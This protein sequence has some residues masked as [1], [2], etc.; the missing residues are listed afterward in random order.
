MEEAMKSLVTGATGFIGSHLAK[1][2][3]SAGDQVRAL[4]RA[5][6]DTSHL[7]QLLCR[8]RH[9]LGPPGPIQRRQY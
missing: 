2:L 4:V 3:A 8:R 7:E 9:R 1:A 6:S 5:T